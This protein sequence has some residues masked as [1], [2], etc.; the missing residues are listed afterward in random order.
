M[1]YNSEDKHFSITRYILA[2]HKAAIITHNMFFLSIKKIITRWKTSSYMIKLFN[3]S[4]QL[5]PS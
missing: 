3:K 2:G 1:H 5:W 4:D